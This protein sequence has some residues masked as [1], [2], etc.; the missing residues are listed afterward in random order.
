[1]SVTPLLATEASVLPKW[2]Y[3]VVPLQTTGRWQ[4]TVDPRVD[5]LNEL[6]QEGWEALGI[7]LAAGDLIAKPVVLLKRPLR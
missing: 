1:M 7:S 5:R 2:E 4:K 3:A 6:G